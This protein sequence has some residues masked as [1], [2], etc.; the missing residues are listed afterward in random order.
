MPYAQRK[1]TQQ[2]LIDKIMYTATNYHVHENMKKAKDP[3][4]FLFYDLS[5]VLLAPRTVR[6]PIRIRF[7]F[8]SLK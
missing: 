8:Q 7:L 1:H 4:P 2:F 6:A 5:E 3:A